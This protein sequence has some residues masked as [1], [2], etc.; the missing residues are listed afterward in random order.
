M[1]CAIFIQQDWQK[2]NIESLSN[3]INLVYSM[4]DF[5]TFQTCNNALLGKQNE[6][7]TSFTKYFTGIASTRHIIK[8]Y[9]YMY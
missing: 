7:Y 9:F 5:N 8:L 4:K 2:K 3:K 6:Y 1:R